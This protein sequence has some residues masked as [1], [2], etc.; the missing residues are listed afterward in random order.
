[1]VGRFDQRQNISAD[2]K[3]SATRGP[4]NWQLPQDE[5]V[6]IIRVNVEFEDAHGRKCNGHSRDAR[7][8][9]G[10]DHAWAFMMQNNGMAPGPATARGEFVT[11][12][13]TVSWK[14]EVE[15]VLPS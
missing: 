13:G 9:Q 10:A 5:G 15:L 12:N 8:A 14:D 1:M 11:E 3:A 2:G 4:I 7:F 6:T